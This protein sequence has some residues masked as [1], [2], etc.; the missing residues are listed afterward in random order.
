MRSISLLRLAGVLSLLVALFQVVIAFSPSWSLYFGA[1]TELV[2]NV[3]LLIVSG[4]ILSVVFVVFG[5][6]GF[7]GAGDIRRLPLLR[8]GLLAVGSVYALRGLLGILQLL[9]VLGI[10]HSEKVIT[11]QL[12][13]SSVVSLIIGVI[14]LFGTINNWQRLT[15]A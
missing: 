8:M 5:L 3:P 14:Y 1:P 2:A 15:K 7:S 12:M 6:Y 9:I 11:P 10:V 13:L 4:A